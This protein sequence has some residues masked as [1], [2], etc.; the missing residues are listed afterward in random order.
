MKN[1]ELAEKRRV[2]LLSYIRELVERRDTRNAQE[3]IEFLELDE[4]AP[5]ILISK[6]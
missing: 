2:E 5:E 1:P 3:V 6:P 4:F